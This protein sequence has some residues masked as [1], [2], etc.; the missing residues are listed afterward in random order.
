MKHSINI[1]IYFLL[2]LG[3]SSC[4]WLDPDCP[5]SVDPI[6]GKLKSEGTV[7]PEP[8]LTETQTDSLAPVPGPNGRGTLVCTETTIE[9]KQRR[10]LANQIVSDGITGVIFPGAIIQGGRFEESGSFTPVTIPKTGGPLVLDGLSAGSD[11]TTNVEAY[12]WDFVKEGINDLLNDLSEEVEGTEAIFSYVNEKVN[13]VKEFRFF[14]GLDVRFP[15]ADIEGKFS[16]NKREEGSRVLLQFTQR[17][18]T[19]S[20]NDPESY[21][22][23]FKDGENFSDPENQMSD[24]NPPLYVKSVHYGRQLFFVAESR[25]STE[26]LK[27]SLDAAYRGTG[28]DFRLNSGLTVK[29]V[30]DNSTVNYIV[31][32][33]S[34]A[35]ALKNAPTYEEV[36]KVISQGA[37][38]SI[39]NP[40]VPIAYELRYLSD[41]SPA[42]MEFS[43]DFTRKSCEYIPPNEAVYEISAKLIHCMDCEPFGEIEGGTA[44]FRGR[45]RVTTSQ[46]GTA[47]DI[48]LNISNVGLNNARK[49]YA[50]DRK[51][52]TVFVEP[53]RSDYINI[54]ATLIEDDPNEDDDFGQI[55][56][57]ISIGDILEVND[58][59]EVIFRFQDKVGTNKEQDARITFRI[60]RS[61]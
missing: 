57:K 5:E 6:T 20:I 4:C 40:G 52:T 39:S 12:D 25:Y 17:F 14:L 26:D 36:Q 2:I 22:S 31:R 42:A 32:G 51:V 50:K 18:Y 15:L 21:Y 61:S 28:P 8:I 24:D 55:K 58:S 59:K 47:E 45:A 38:W 44:E 56:K 1:L 60:F 9:A 10:S 19:I 23:L 11:V 54:D 13:S 41:R 49:D 37:E 3:F 27:A 30:L 29:E 35:L 7:D 53:G 16:L 43:T 46:I 34:A 33:G 48:N